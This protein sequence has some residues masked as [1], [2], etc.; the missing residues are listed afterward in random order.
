ML[1]SAR[2]FQTSTCSAM[3]G[4]H[5]FDAQITVQRPLRADHFVLVADR[6]LLVCPEQQTFL[7]SSA[8]FKGRIPDMAKQPNQVVNGVD[9]LRH[10]PAGHSRP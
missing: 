6:P 8:C 1:C 3:P 2:V 7:A 9:R 10:P 5:Y 4:R